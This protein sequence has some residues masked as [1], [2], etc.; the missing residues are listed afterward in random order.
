MKKIGLLIGVLIVF[1]L[2]SNLQYKKIIQHPIKP[3]T[4]LHVNVKNGDT[5]YSILDDLNQNGV[6]KNSNIINIQNVINT[7]LFKHIY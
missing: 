5:L 2:A 4:D 6:I 3:K 7:M 1:V